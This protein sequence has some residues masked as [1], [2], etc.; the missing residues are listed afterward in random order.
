MSCSNDMLITASAAEREVPNSVTIDS[1]AA[2]LFLA[3]TMAS[4]TSCRRSS[5]ASSASAISRRAAVWS[6]SVIAQA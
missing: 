2:A 3:S 5:A 6:W 1:T 4:A